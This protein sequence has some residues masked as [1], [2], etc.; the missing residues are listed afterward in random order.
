MTF[1]IFMLFVSLYCLHISFHIHMCFALQAQLIYIYIYICLYLNAP[2]YYK[3]ISIAL[4]LLY[5]Q[6]IFKVCMHKFDWCTD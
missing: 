6:Y 1:Y 5:A 3:R 4:I 2:I